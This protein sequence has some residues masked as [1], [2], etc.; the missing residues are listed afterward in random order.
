MNLKM[1]NLGPRKTP[2]KLPF[3]IDTGKYCSR[4]CDFDRNRLLWAIY[5]EWWRICHNISMWMTLK[6]VCRMNP[7]SLP[8]DWIFFQKCP[9]WWL[10][11]YRSDGRGSEWFSVVILDASWR[12]LIGILTSGVR[13]G[14]DSCLWNWQESEK[15]E[16]YAKRTLHIDIIMKYCFLIVL[17]VWRRW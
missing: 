12:K 3:I 11:G 10:V 16:E 17:Q 15:S 6:G 13:E 8:S 4:G 7:W 5:I 2:D 14:G 1:V 9:I